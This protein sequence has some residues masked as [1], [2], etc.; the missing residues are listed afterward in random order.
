MCK[1]TPD[2]PKEICGCYVG[3][4]LQKIEPFWCPMEPLIFQQKQAIFKDVSYS[5]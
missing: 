2:Y 4:F 3:F 5:F 1:C